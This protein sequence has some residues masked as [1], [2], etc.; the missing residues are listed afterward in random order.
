MARLVQFYFL[1]L[2]IFVVACLAGM[3]AL[4]FGNVVLRYVFNSGITEAEEFS[5]WLFV[6]MIFAGA[7]I[8]LRDNGHLGIDFVVNALPR[9]LRQACLALAHALMLYATWLIIHGSWTLTKVN[10]NTFAPATGLSQSLF[11]GIG[12]V[13]GVSTAVLLAARLYLILVGRL[14]HLVI[15]DEE[16]I[17]V[18]EA[19]RR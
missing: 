16:V 12:L 9:R 13:F 10:L 18:A 19:G 6:W 17:A 5:R 3:V 4:V 2:K 11:F 15:V 14:D 7:I 8:V 1:L